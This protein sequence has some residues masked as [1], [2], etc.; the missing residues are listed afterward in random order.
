MQ[1]A[2]R[3]WAY[4]SQ[5]KRVCTFIRAEIHSAKKNGDDVMTQFHAL[6]HAINDNGT[7]W[8]DG[9]LLPAVY[10]C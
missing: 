8:V 5:S 2:V 1:N 4:L 10:L 6:I 9:I 7:D 3:W